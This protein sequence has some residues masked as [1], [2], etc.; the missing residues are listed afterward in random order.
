MKG[1]IFENTTIENPTGDFEECI[2]ISVIFK[3]K[4]DCV[5]RKCLV[6]DVTL[7]DVEII[8]WE[9]PD[10][11]ISSIVFE[12]NVI[13]PVHWLKT[14]LSLKHNHT[15]ITSRMRNY[16][17]TLDDENLK[18]TIF[19]ACQH[20]DDHPELSWNDFLDV[21]K[22]VWDLAEKFFEDLPEIVTHAVNVREKRWP[23][24]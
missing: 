2:F 8:R 17:S 3:G 11:D 15:F 18:D 10:T 20:I 21:P 12:K 9:T 22:E 7:E 19:F 24:K 1:E 4:V 14:I 6:K 16:A 13:E 5:W 23:T